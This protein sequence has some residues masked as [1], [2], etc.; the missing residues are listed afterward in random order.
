MICCGLTPTID[1]G[2]VYRRVVQ[3]IRSDKIS[4]KLS[5]TIMDSHLLHG[6]ISWSWRVCY[7][8]LEF[9]VRFAGLNV[10]FFYPKITRLQLGS[11]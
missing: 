4:Q 3:V 8:F 11:R 9:Y 5:T 6:H 7:S 2:G 10:L 1:V